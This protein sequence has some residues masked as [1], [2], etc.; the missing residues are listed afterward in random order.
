MGLGCDG[1]GGALDP[2]AAT[3]AP[4][5]DNEQTIDFGTPIFIE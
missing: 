1:G 2:H 4:Q 3:R 5:K